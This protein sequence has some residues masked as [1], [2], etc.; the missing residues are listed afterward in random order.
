MKQA[1]TKDVGKHYFQIKTSVEENDVRDMLTRLYNL[2]FI[3]VAPTESKLKFSMSVEDQKFT[4]ILQEGTNLRNGHY[5]VPLSFKDPCVNLPN[6]RYQAR[7]KFSY[8]EKRFSKNDQFKENYIRFMKN[9]I[10]KDY[11]RKSTTETA[12]VKTWY[13]THHGVYHPNKPRK[14]RVAF[15]LNADF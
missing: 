2:E 4:K 13:L 9:I 10:A 11:A 7:Q 8:L 15:D 14:I 3:E 5:E 12:S 6:K 1:D